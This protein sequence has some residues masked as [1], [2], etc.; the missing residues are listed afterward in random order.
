M[1]N[2]QFQDH[3]SELATTA[4]RMHD[5][6]HNAMGELDDYMID[7]YGLDIESIIFDL[8]CAKTD[9]EFLLRVM[10]MLGDSE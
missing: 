10:R 2:K 8:K 6:L 4:N 9:C 3:L 5:S 7:N 1:T